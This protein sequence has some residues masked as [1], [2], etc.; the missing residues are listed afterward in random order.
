MYLVILGLIWLIFLYCD[1]HHHQ[2]MMRKRGRLE[3]SVW[4][5]GHRVKADDGFHKNDRMSHKR[6]ST[7]PSTDEIDTGS[8][9]ISHIS[10]SVSPRLAGSKN[11]RKS[12]YTFCRSRHSGSFYL[13]IGAAGKKT[14]VFYEFKTGY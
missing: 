6:A 7:S 11:W 8:D 4:S 12:S 3:R 5:H 10:I 14:N 13:K 9:A 2:N 1:I